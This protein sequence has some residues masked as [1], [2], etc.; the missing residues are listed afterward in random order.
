MG[1]F[2][3]GADR[4][5]DGCEIQDMQLGLHA[6]TP[7]VRQLFGK[8]DDGSLVRRSR[9]I[10]KEKLNFDATFHQAPGSDRGIKAAGQ[11]T[12]DATADAERQTAR[13]VDAATED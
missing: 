2:Y 7:F 13:T 9:E 6:K 12:D 4:L 8:T 10:A 11:K 5:C 3:F 1:R